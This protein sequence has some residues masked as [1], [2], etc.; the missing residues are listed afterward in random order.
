MRPGLSYAAG[1]ALERDLSE[2]LDDRISE[3]CPQ[4]IS[5]PPIHCNGAAGVLRYNRE[6]DNPGINLTTILQANQPLTEYPVRCEYCGEKAKPSLDLTWVH[7]PETVFCCARWQQLCEMLVEQTRS[8]AEMEEHLIQAREMEGGNK[9]VMELQQGFGKQPEQR[10]SEVHSIQLPVAETY[11]CW[12]SR[13]LRFRLSC[14]PETERCTECPNNPNKEKEEVLLPFCN[15]K[16]L[17]FGLCHHQDGAEFLQKNYSSGM[18]FLAAF[19]D[20]SAQV[21]YPSGLLAVVV[22]VTEGNGRVCIVYDDCDANYQPIRAVFLS[23][24]RSTCYHRNGNIWLALNTSGGQCLDEKGARVRQWTWSSLPPT[25]LHPVFLS[26]N[27]TVGVRVLGR[28]QVFLSFLARGRQ[29]K[30][31]VGSCCTQDD[32]KTNMAASGPSLLKEELFVS[33]ARIRIHLAFLQLHQFLRTPS[34]PRLPKTS[35]VRHLLAVAQRLVAVSADVMMS[36]RDRA[37]IHRCLR[38]CLMYQ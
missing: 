4:S 29:A 9:F 8:A 25:P 10:A 31:S 11:A 6:S 7:Q 36:E 23:D 16:S 35:Q 34:H 38:D 30:F 18:R 22:V 32:C 1:S 26:L 37:F 24:G 2:P 12:T 17:Q 14:A 27:T 20:G 21:F 3:G 19:S 33:A 15:H 5:D 28:A 13:V